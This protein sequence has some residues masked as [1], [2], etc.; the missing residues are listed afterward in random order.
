MAAHD[1]LITLSDLAQYQAKVRPPV[2]GSYRG[3]RIASMPPPSSGGVH[4]IQMLNIL[5]GFPI[6]FL[7]PNSADSLHVMAE[8]MKFAYADRSKHLGDTDFWPVPMT[9][10]TSKRY[11]RELRGRIDINRAMPSSAIA[12]GQPPAAQSADTTHFSVMDSAGNAVANTYTINFSY[13]SGLM[14]AGTGILLNN[15]MDDFSAKSGV[16]NAYGLLGGDANAIEPRKRPLSSMTPTLVFKDGHPMLATGSPGG[17]RIITTTL[18]IIMNVIDHDMN[19]AQAVTAARVHHQWLPDELRIEEGISPDTQQ[20]LRDRG[21]QLELKNA[22]G[23]A[24][25]VRRI[26]GGF[27]GMADPRRAGALAEGY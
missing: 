18:Q 10:L 22:M 9:G 21:H 4:L 8:T 26:A 20:R 19:L 23:S 5:E 11:A 27:T 12:P 2:F 7:G 1:G 24:N 6:R 3:Y 14:A 17:S 25:S 13:G 15:E 16:P